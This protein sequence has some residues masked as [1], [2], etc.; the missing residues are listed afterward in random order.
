MPSDRSGA[1][2]LREVKGEVMDHKG[3]V[4][5]DEYPKVLV[6]IQVQLGRIEKTLEAVPALAATLESTKELART[7]EQSAKSAHHRLD[8]LHNAKDV[9]DE[10]NRKAESALL[11]LDKTD[12]NQKW[13]KRTFLGA[14][15]TVFAGAIVVALWAGIKLA[16]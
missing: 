10:A 4:D 16:A 12:E 15:I 6:D 2:F 13:L 3:A 1:I 5:M 14:M 9:A 8:L 7:A 11:R